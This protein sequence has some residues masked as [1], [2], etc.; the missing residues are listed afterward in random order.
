[1]NASALADAA[2]IHLLLDTNVYIHNFAGTLPGPAA[3]L[4][5]RALQWHCSVCLGEITAGLGHYDP[6]AR[7]WKLLRQRYATLFAAIP[8]TRLLVPDDG[9]WHLAGMVSGV[10]A[11]TQNFQPHQRKEC[12]N[13]ALI[14][15]TAAKEGVAVLTANRV[16]FDLI[17]Q[18]AP[19]GAFVYF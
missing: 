4:L 12:L 5:D 2:R 11:R 1:V 16:E 10:L 6:A 8:D 19:G 3:G 18:I 13:D 14:S 17:Q 7:D 15:L 9:V